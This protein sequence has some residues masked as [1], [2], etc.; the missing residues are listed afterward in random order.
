MASKFRLPNKVAW[1]FEIILPLLVKGRHL[2][3]RYRTRLKAAKN[4][5]IK[6]QDF[7]MLA[8]LS[9]L[10]DLQ[11]IDSLLAEVESRVRDAK[12][13]IFNEETVAVDEIK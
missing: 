6:N 5:A 11:E 4:L 8:H 12:D 2:F 13:G 7:V 1:N 10:D 9:R 3:S